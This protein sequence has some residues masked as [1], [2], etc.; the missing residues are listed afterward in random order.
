VG[1]V[2]KIQAGDIHAHAHEI[3]HRLFGI[4]C[5]PNCANNFGAA[6]KR[7][8]IRRR[9]FPLALFQESIL[10]AIGLMSV[11]YMEIGGE[12]VTG[13]ARME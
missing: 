7:G 3:A 4:A 1:A 6:S 5:R 12:D 2:G 8:R 9:Q 10:K 13:C 11:L